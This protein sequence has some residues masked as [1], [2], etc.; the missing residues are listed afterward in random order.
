MNILVTGATGF[1]GTH[2]ITRLLEQ[3]HTVTA[4]AR[5]PSRA[6]S[7]SWGGRVTFIACDIHGLAPL[8]Q[9]QLTRFDAVIH[10]AWPG[11]P[12]YS[13]LS[14]LDQTFPA[15]CAFLKGLIQAG[16]SHLLITGTCFEYGLRQGCLNEL[17]IPAPVTPYAVAK[18]A[19]RCYLE[20]LKKEFPFR[21][22]WARLFYMYGEGQ[23][24]GSLLAQLNA[25]IERGDSVFNM[26]RGEQLRDYLPVEEIA[27]H[28]VALVEHSTS[29]GI[30][31]VCSG[32]PISVR[33]LVED[34][35]GKRGAEISLN[36]GYYSYP[37]YEPMA[38]WG[39]STKLIL[40]RT[41]PGIVTT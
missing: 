20:A 13:A 3:G 40:I 39:D 11:L 34:H 32:T 19:L 37:D 29:D 22:Q 21:L 33:R 9:L 16:V 1:I 31:N 27:S 15:E 30:V 36:L 6:A 17:M 35:I 23:S 38:Y 28:L 18:N 12:N 25:A 24:K 2:V 26:S 10:L 4:V 8:E 41:K 5:N 7:S 14:H